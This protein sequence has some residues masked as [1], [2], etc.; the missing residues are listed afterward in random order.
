MAQPT[1]QYVPSSDPK[2]VAQR[3]Q[4]WKVFWILLG[5]T[6]AEFVIAFTMP[7]NTLRVSIFIGMTLIKAFYI[8]AEF[9]HLKHE[10][11][12]LIWS[13]VLPTVFLFWMLLA[14]FIEGDYIF[15]ERW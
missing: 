15:G 11:K 12:V 6:A 1:G 13:I 14:F 3:K 5:L 10:V 8:V 9:M 2:S 4:I 7:A